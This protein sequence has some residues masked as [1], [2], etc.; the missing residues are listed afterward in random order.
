MEKS[1]AYN[2][3]VE[4]KETYKNLFIKSSGSIVWP[5]SYVWKL[6]P[7]QLTLQSLFYSY[8]EKR[9]LALHSGLVS[10]V[11]T[12]GFYKMRGIKKLFLIKDSVQ[13]S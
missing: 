8:K 11:R 12:C 6:L 4:S 3:K 5:E 13:W 7:K 9:A 10:M 2:I 1:L